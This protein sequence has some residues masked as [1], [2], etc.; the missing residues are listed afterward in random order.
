MP[1]SEQSR[2]FI[3]YA[4]KDGA[5]LAQRLQQSLREQGFDAWLDTQRL[6]GGVVWSAEIER[7]IKTRQVVIALMSPGSYTSETCCRAW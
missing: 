7:E 4:H 1:P 5:D 3:S 2:I 6:C